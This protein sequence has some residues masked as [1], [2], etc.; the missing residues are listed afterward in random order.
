[1]VFCPNRDFV[2]VVE[3]YELIISGTFSSGTKKRKPQIL[4]AAIA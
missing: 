1:M 3:L 2:P 4:N